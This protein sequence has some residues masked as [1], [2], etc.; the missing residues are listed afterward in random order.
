MHPQIEDELTVIAD[1]YFKK[2]TGQKAA[3]IEEMY[4]AFKARVMLESKLE[5]YSFSGVVGGSIVPRC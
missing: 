5:G 4:Q 2:L 1:D 3:E